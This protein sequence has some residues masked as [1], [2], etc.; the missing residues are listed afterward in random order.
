MFRRVVTLQCTEFG[1]SVLITSVVAF[2]VRV[3]GYRLESLSLIVGIPDWR[4][5][6]GLMYW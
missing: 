1:A 2:H 6:S 5:N 4:I 3:N